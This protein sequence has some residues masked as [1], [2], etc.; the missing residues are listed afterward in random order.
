MKEWIIRQLNLEGI[1]IKEKPYVP[2]NKILITQILWFGMTMAGLLLID[3]AFAKINGT[4]IM[5]THG[6]IL[7]FTIVFGVYFVWTCIQLRRYIFYITLIIFHKMRNNQIAVALTK[8]FFFKS[9]KVLSKEEATKKAKF[10][11]TLEG[12]DASIPEKNDALNRMIAPGEITVH[13]GDLVQVIVGHTP[14]SLPNIKFPM[15]SK[16]ALDGSHNNPTEVDGGDFI[17]EQAV[18]EEEEE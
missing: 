11:E 14:Q 17:N 8:L 1:S 12:L 16:V 3:H 2:V 13:D 5:Q 10:F 15:A 9:D 7:T 6:K 4:S 18:K